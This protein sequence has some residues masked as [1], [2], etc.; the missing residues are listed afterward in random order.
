MRV[1]GKCSLWCLMRHQEVFP[2]GLNDTAE[3][4]QDNFAPDHI[5]LTLLK[6]SESGDAVSCAV[7]VEPWLDCHEEAI[8]GWNGVRV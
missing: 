5:P 3:K 7:G 4:D 8:C 2:Q 6:V 1:Y